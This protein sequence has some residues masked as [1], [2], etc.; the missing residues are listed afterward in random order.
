MDP[1]EQ[2]SQQAPSP[3]RSDKSSDSEGKPV[4][5]KLKETTLDA[6]APPTQHKED[7]PTNGAHGENNSGSDSD[8]GRLRRK[9]SREDF[10]DEDAKHPEKKQE[11]HTRKKSRDVTS[12]SGSDLESVKPIK[13]LIPSIKE[14]DSGES[15]R[16]VTRKATPESGA[17]DK[18]PAVTSPKNKRT[19][20]Q[21]EETATGANSADAGSDNSDQV[22][23]SEDER[24][25]KRPRDGGVDATT[26]EPPQSKT[27][28]SSTVSCAYTTRLTSLQIPPG[29]GF[30]NT[31]AASP[32]ATMSPQK[33]APKS[34]EPSAKDLPQTSDQ[35][36]KNSGFGSFA[37]STTSPFGA[38]A[39]GSGSALGA[40]TGPKL[41]SF[42]SPKKSE[43][44]PLG[45][46][47]LGGSSS[48]TSAFGGAANGA[49]PLFGGALGA[50]TFGSAGGVSKLSSFGSG[51]GSIIGLTQKP[52][53]F[54]SKEQPKAEA[55]DDSSDKED[56]ANGDDAEEQ[57]TKSR[58]TLLPSQGP[59]ET[60]EENEDVT[61][62]GHVKLYTLA[63]EAGKK[64]WQ[65]RGTGTLKVNVTR[66]PPN[67]A[68]FVLRAD[69]THRLLLNVAIA[70][71][72]RFGDVE[73]K[74]P[75]DGKVLFTAP[76]A[77]GEVESHLLRVSFLPLF[78]FQ[79][80]SRFDTDK[81]SKLKVDKGI[82]LWHTVEDLKKQSS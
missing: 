5:E 17:S 42:A 26:T 49:K 70:Q 34:T 18:K 43:A 14:D 80:Y 48:G 30:S 59:P 36:F 81:P 8:R 44:Q 66:E 45:F 82:D 61:W 4:R 32:F 1:Q 73:G 69:A 68:R 21:A 63:G 23:R 39:A 35:A 74:E 71:S 31:S 20:E 25:T 52:V 75:K 47:S 56:A 28:V 60:G 22:S 15:K 38:V 7:A 76:T 62:T 55:D 29:S 12:P 16:S 19:R 37:S 57:S 54:G 77:S 10:E 24:T 53:E 50:S 78:S 2:T 51:G 9:R 58:Q 11:R 79:T 40:S 33:A 72:L 3:T 6:Q 67:K 64:A 13:P 41:S 46:A 65:E 27:K